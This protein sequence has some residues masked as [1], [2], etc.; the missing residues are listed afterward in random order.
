MSTAERLIRQRPGG[1]A[2]FNVAIEIY[3]DRP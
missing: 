2:V 1:D 3:G